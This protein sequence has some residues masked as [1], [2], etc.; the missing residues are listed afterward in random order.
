MNFSKISVQKFLIGLIISGIFIYLSLR[1]IDFSNILRGLKTV[2]YG[3]IFPSL[4]LFFLLQVLRSLRWGIILSPMAKVNQ[5]ALFPVTCIGYL[6]ITLVP[7]RFGEIVRPYL[8]SIKKEIPLSSSLATVLV[9]RVLDVLT[10]VAILFSVLMVLPLPDW[11]F[12]SGVVFLGI[13][14]SS[15]AIMGL[16]VLKTDDSL[17]FFNPIFKLF[18]NRLNTKMNSLLRTF[19]EGFMVISDLKKIGY[20]LFLTLLIWGAS[21]LAIYMLFSFYNFQIPLVGAFVVL[22]MTALGIILPTAPG[23]LGNFQFACIL[24]LSFFGIPKTDAFAFSMV[25]YIFGI[26]INIILGLVFLPFEKISLREIK[27]HRNY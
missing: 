5:K 9:E 2:R 15:V 3:F 14:L 12:N 20:I 21:G 22:T 16:F 8:I 26:G 7:M 10:L 13:V 18:P 17:R 24:A 27:S 23:F 6:A 11:V 1:G 25:Y 19:I 4:L